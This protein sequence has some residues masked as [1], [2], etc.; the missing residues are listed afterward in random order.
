MAISCEAGKTWAIIFGVYSGILTG[1]ILGFL[2]LKFLQRKVSFCSKWAFPKK[3]LNFR[4]SFQKTIPKAKKVQ[5][6][7]NAAFAESGLGVTPE[8]L[9]EDLNAQR[10]NRKDATPIP[11][12]RES[13]GEPRQS[14]AESYHT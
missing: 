2:I 12:R 6:V 7:E 11:V 4:A 13:P 14:V 8:R 10:R 5:G 3:T 1:V 9:R